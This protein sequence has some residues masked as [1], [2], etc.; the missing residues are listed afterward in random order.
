MSLPVQIGQSPAFFR[1][2]SG[3]CEGER[4]VAGAGAAARLQTAT[5]SRFQL[6]RKPLICIVWQP[7]VAN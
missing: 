2:F 5:G 4:G 6:I 7:E 1:I 3:L